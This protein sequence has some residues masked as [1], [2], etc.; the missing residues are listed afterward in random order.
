M[1]RNGENPSTNHHLEGKS[2]SGSFYPP[3]GVWYTTFCNR[4]L[5]KKYLG[6][7]FVSVNYEAQWNPT[8]QM[9][10]FIDFTSHRY[11]YPKNDRVGMKNKVLKCDDILGF[12]E[13][14]NNSS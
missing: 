3:N 14:L 6:N 7:G 13:V 4:Y 8:S 9:G 5:P 10:K 11:F 1:S 12:R 2:K